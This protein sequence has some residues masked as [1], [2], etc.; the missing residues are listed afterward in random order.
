[1]TNNDDTD[2]NEGDEDAQLW[3]AAMHDVT[4]LKGRNPPKIPKNTKKLPKKSLKRPNSDKN[5]RKID[6]IPQNTSKNS[7]NEVDR[8]SFERFRKGEM[9]IEARLDLHHM[10][11]EQAHKTL[12]DF[13][14]R[15][16]AAGK[17]CVLVITGK[18]EREKGKAR[19][20]DHWLSPET[21]VLRKHVPD[22][23]QDPALKPLI[24]KTSPAQPKD[25]GTGALYVLLRRRR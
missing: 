3:N 25:G 14:L 9:P 12:H 1:M 17:R 4:P 10:N 16:Y 20:D 2:D 21:G 5:R 11:Q 19:N 7:G 13:I 6:K 18:G 23:L 15:S 8:R 22:W 24:L